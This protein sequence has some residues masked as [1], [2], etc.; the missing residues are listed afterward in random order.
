MIRSVVVAGALLLGIGAVMAQQDVAVKQ[1]NLMR[2][3]GKSMYGVILKTVKGEIPYD[4]KAIDAAFK[5]LE[6]SVPTIPNAFTTNPKEDVV[7]ATYGSS[8]KI[9]QNKADFDSKV[10]P[11][12]KALAD[13]KG[14]AKDVASLKVAFDTV[15][16]KCTDCHETYRLKLK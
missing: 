1:D 16:A 8:Q 9:W 11:V 5:D 6:A 3:Q 13:V 12:A 2:A 15:Q 10:P 4:Q 14:T 7:N